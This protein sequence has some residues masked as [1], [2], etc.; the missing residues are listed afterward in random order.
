MEKLP[1]GKVLAKT[2]KN[3]SQAQWCTNSSLMRIT[4]LAVWASMISDP[5]K[6]KAVI[7]AEAEL[8]HRSPVVHDAAFVYSQAIA[9]LL[10]NE[11]D[12]AGAF[13]HVTSEPILALVTAELEGESVGS[14]L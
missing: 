3:A 10:L 6:H 13:K 11:G 5:T 14:W 8:T 2:L 1:E 9:Y 12:A 4:P 7:T